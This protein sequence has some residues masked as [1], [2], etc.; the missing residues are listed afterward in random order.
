[1]QAGEAVGLAVDGW[2]AGVFTQKDMVRERSGKT[3]MRVEKTEEKVEYVVLT[4]PILEAQRLLN[5]LTNSQA[6]WEQSSDPE[7]LRILYNELDP[8]LRT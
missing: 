6:I 8:L 5:L 3:G 4:L 1:M 7:L 2:S